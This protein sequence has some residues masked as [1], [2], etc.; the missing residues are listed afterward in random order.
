MLSWLWIYELSDDWPFPVPQ[1]ASRHSQLV[2]L[3]E[4]EGIHLSHTRGFFSHIFTTTSDFYFFIFFWM[5]IEIIVVNASKYSL[6]S[7][8]RRGWWNKSEICR[9]NE[10][11]RPFLKKF[12]WGEP[13]CDINGSICAEVLSG[14]RFSWAEGIPWFSVRTVQPRN[15]FMALRRRQKVW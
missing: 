8:V 7:T 14:R 6:L 9:P 15:T 3:S 2:F 10:E 12:F 11:L 13:V 4:G 1:H 5:T